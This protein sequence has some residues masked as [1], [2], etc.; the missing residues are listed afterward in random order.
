MFL[1]FLKLMTDESK[2]KEISVK[3]GKD[4]KSTDYQAKLNR[5][6]SFVRTCC[7]VLLWIAYSLLDVFV[8]HCL[9]RI[10]PNTNT[11]QT[12]WNSRLSTEFLIVLG[13]YYRVI[14]FL[15]YLKI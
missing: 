11:K 13:V 9:P 14:P 6:K 2:V 10:L 12:T 7:F 5:T 1:K 15:Y 4:T 8:E 3:E